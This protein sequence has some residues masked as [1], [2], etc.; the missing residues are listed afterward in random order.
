MRW[1]ESSYGVSYEVW[2]ECQPSGWY[3][4]GKIYQTRDD[5]KPKSSLELKSYAHKRRCF[6]LAVVLPIESSAI[7]FAAAILGVEF[8]LNIMD[9][10]FT[11][12]WCQMTKKGGAVKSIGNCVSRIPKWNLL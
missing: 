1:K 8:G 5:S 3:L 2:N 10:P 4:V 7:G 12:E 9:S 11:V 6:K